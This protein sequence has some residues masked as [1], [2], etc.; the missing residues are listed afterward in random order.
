MYSSLFSKK[1]ATLLYN[2]AGSVHLFSAPYF[3]RHRE[4]FGMKMHG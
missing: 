4:A 2:P 1:G 3:E